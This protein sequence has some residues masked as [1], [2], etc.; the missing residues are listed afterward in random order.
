MKEVLLI[1]GSHLFRE[2][3]KEKLAEEQV[4]LENATGNR[5]AYTKIITMLPLL[6]II[7]ANDSLNSD[8]MDLLEKKRND[9]NARR[10]PVILIGPTIERSKAATLVEY[11]VV[12]YFTKPIRFD[13][14]FEAIG[15]ILRQSFSF[16]ETPC[17]LDIHIN[18]N[19]IFVEIA[20][21][22]NREKL[23]LI[24]YKISEIITLH[25]LVNPK[26]I[27]ML[28]NL[29]LSF[30]DGANLELLF[31]NITA[32]ERL[33]KRNIKVL[34]LDDF[35]ADLIEGHPQYHG[36]E[37]AHNLQ[38]ILNSLVDGSRSSGT[39]ITDFVSDKILMS[40]KGT[41]DGGAEI[42]FGE[43]TKDTSASTG[44]LLKIAIVDD[45]VIVRKI[46]QSTFSAISGDCSLYQNG[47][48]FVK[49]IIS[50]QK[51]DLI[52]LDLYINDMDGLSILR[53]LQKHNVMTPVIIYSQ[54]TQREMIFQAMSLG[55]KDFIEKPKKPEEILRRAVKVLH[56]S[57]S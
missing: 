31:D 48:E 14:F 33:S 37:V 26:V 12:K 41:D 38:H 56:S 35:V 9:P 10:K 17:I 1:D 55:A 51:F 36:I 16:D 42:R 7:E 5:D 20:R 23:F 44:N 53:T 45:D 11:G 43:Q 2:F 49:A 21:G 39:N 47:T 3:L 30:V 40:E 27:L 50:G 24:K 15:S 32:D 28:T 52:I 57:A 54:A 46:L 34:S 29:Q 8:I 25:K 18:G 19:L 13:V 6:I 4:H 22:L